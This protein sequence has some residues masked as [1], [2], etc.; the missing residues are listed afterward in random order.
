MHMEE[1][2]RNLIKVYVELSRYIA[3]QDV[4]DFYLILV[5]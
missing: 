2:I 4:I 1:K 3:A 5:L